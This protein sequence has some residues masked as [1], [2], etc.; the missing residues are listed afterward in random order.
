MKRSRRALALVPKGPDPRA[1]AAPLD[2]VPRLLREGAVHHNARRFWQAHEAWE[3]AWHALRAAGRAGA[4]G[5]VRGM[6]LATAALENAA[7]GKED[8][9]KRQMAEA[10][11][12]LHEHAS[13]APLRDARGWE[14]ALVVLYVDACRRHEWSR[15][16]ESGWQAPPVELA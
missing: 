10:L 1:E 4:A 16:N 14:R 15:W 12:A 3:R 9:F 6:I 8:G 13:D 5:Y 2:D 11:Y 7:R